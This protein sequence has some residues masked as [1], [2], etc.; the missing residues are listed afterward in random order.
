[1]QIPLTWFWQ[2]GM[3][4]SF[5][6]E[7]IVTEPFELKIPIEQYV[8]Y[9]NKRLK[10]A[11]WQTVQALLIGLALNLESPPPL[12]QILNPT[13]IGPKQWPTP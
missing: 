7:S 4:N 8:D 1:M 6:D 2:E 12:P 5:G 13:A 9:K 11:T 10:F 3:G